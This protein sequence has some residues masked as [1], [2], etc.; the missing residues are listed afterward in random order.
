M[1]TI[2]QSWR[3]FEEETLS[4]DISEDQRLDMKASFYAGAQAMLAMQYDIISEKVSDEAWQGI[5]SGWQY[6]IEIFAK[7]FS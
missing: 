3:E 6:E 5:M 2:Q 1:N 4:D 7:T